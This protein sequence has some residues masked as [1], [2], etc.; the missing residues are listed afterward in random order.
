MS[1]HQL[2]AMIPLQFSELRGIDVIAFDYDGCL[3]Q[4][5]EGSGEYGQYPE[6]TRAF[7]KYVQQYA[8][9]EVTFCSFSNRASKVINLIEEV[10]QKGK[11]INDEGEISE[12]SMLALDKF[13]TLLENDA[14]KHPHQIHV[15]KT[16][17]YDP[18]LAGAGVRNDEEVALYKKLL[19]SSRANSTEMRALSADINSTQFKSMALTC[20]KLI[21]GN[22]G[23]DTKMKLAGR[24]CHQYSGK[25]ILFVDDKL[26]YLH[27]VD[28]YANTMQLWLRPVILKTSQCLNKYNFH[29]LQQ[30]T[31]QI[32]ENPADLCHFSTFKNIFQNCKQV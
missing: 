20:T 26:E 12:P 22:S 11:V 8:S 10:R 28:R 4:I 13:K 19:L 6:V 5:V 7:M 32:E 17:Y 1:K 16:Y 25:K 15:D 3:K 27:T 14:L 24:I 31:A 18:F 2:S 9:R 30:M 29:Q 23:K 21:T